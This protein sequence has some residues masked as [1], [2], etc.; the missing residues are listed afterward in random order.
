MWKQQAVPD[1]TSLRQQVLFSYSHSMFTVGWWGPCFM[2]SLSSPWG[3]GCD[4]KKRV[5]EA[6]TLCFHLPTHR[7]L[8]TLGSHPNTR[9]VGSA[10]SYKYSMRKMDEYCNPGVNGESLMSWNCFFNIISSTMVYYHPLSL[11]F[12]NYEK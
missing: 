1:L 4:R 9:A 12:R 2:S 5:L 6:L 7:L 11:Y 3:T 8:L 10:E